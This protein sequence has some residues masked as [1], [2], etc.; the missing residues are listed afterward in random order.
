MNIYRLLKADEMFCARNR[1]ND[2][3]KISAVS[4]FLDTV[5]DKKEKKRFQNPATCCC[6]RQFET[7][8]PY[9]HMLTSFDRFAS[10]YHTRNHYVSLPAQWRPITASV[11]QA[12]TC[13]SDIL[14]CDDFVLQNFWPML[15]CRSFP[16]S[17]LFL[18]WTAEWRPRPIAYIYTVASRGQLLE[19]F[20]GPAPG[21]FLVLFMADVQVFWSRR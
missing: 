9:N 15:N 1:F 10:D 2:A 7:A 11:T 8:S 4:N 3:L 18:G 21:T 19:I 12:T 13:Q 16:P 17:L 20:C 14:T 5:C 6:W